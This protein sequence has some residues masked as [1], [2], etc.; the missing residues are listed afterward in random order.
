M[1]GCVGGA[2]G[3]TVNC[4]IWKNVIIVQY[5]FY[6][7]IL[8]RRCSIN[9][10]KKKEKSMTFSEKDMYKELERAVIG[11]IYEV[12]FNFMSCLS[13]LYLAGPQQEFFSSKKLTI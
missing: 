2:W 10:F 8:Y 9:I 7:L 3:V 5:L 13:W 1:G 11:S 12:S 4:K 6:V